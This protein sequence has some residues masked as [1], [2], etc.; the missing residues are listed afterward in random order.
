[1]PKPIPAK[2]YFCGF[3]ACEVLKSVNFLKKVKIICKKFAGYKK[4]PYLCIVLG[5]QTKILTKKGVRPERATQLAEMVN[6]PSA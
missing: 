3:F 5:T 6:A 2:H 1:M 4:P